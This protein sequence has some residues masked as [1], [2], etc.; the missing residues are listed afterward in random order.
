MEQLHIGKVTASDAIVQEIVETEDFQ[1]F[2]M[3]CVRRHRNGDWGD[4]PKE[5][6]LQNN[7][8]ARKGG[9]IRSEYVIPRIF[10][11]GY[12]DRITVTTNED[13]TETE[14]CFLETNM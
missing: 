14:I 10:C 9:V 12:A 8:A 3:G 6:W 5:D 4:I 1:T 2:C 11:L 13:R 7:R